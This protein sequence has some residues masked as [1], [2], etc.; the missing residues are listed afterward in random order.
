MRSRTGG[1]TNEQQDKDERLQEHFS[2]VR[3]QCQTF[4]QSCEPV[5]LRGTHNGLFKILKH[6]NY[7]TSLDIFGWNG[8]IELDSIKMKEWRLNECKLKLEESSWFCWQCSN[9]VIKFN[10]H[11]VILMLNYRNELWFEFLCNTVVFE[12]FHRSGSIL[13][14]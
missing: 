9:C 6:V 4:H 7:W 10:D 3:P 5:W 1:R 12:I 14:F 11:L 2:P 8:W 13:L